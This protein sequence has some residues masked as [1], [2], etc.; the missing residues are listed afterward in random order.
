MRQSTLYLSSDLMDRSGEFNENMTYK[1]GNI[2]TIHKTQNEIFN[3]Y[4]S[5]NTNRAREV[6]IKFAET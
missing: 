2:Q 4:L 6:T 5:N 3:E 1:E